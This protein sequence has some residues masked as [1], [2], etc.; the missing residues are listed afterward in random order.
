MSTPHFPS[1]ADSAPTSDTLSDQRQLRRE[2]CAQLAAVTGGIAPDDY[3]AAWWDWYLNI[4]KRPQKPSALTAAA[5]QGALDTWQFALQA[6][7]GAPLA[8]S[9]EDPRFAGGPWSQWPFIER[10]INNAM[11]MAKKGAARI[12]L[13]S[14]AAFVARRSP[15]AS[16]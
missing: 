14:R 8:P 9:P 1:S 7:S 11:L 2:L 15:C 5:L 4:A 16:C 10:L 12:A 3:V 6:G 13:H